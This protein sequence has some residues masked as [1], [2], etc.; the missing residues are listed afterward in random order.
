MYE[1][2][3]TTRKNQTI[4][5]Q[6]RV[7][8]TISFFT[9]H[10]FH[11]IQR[12]LPRRGVHQQHRQ[13]ETRSAESCPRGWSVLQRLR[14]HENLLR[15]PGRMLGH[16][17]L[18]GRDGRQSRGHQVHFRDESQKRGLRGRRIVRR[19]ENGKCPV[20]YTADDSV[21]LYLAEDSFTVVILWKMSNSNAF[22]RNF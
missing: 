3:K 13:E 14:W 18:L 20:L 21:C 15:G 12:R 5:I 7:R 16:A 19:S 22:S 17:G 2:Y 9:F 11:S 4:L 8:N 6:H 1:K 10:G